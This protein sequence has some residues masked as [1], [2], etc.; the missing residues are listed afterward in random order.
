MP[1]NLLSKSRYINGLQCL[2]YLWITYNDPERIPETDTVTQYIFDQ[3]HVVG[4][5]AKKLF[6]SAI[7]TSQDDFM[8][9]YGKT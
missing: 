7:D 1:F 3:G 8:E 6:P 4:E 2:K 5:L 9:G